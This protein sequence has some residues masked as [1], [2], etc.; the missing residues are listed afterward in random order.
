MTAANASLGVP[1][2]PQEMLDFLAGFDFLLDD[3][4]GFRQ[5]QTGT[6]Q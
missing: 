2:E 4:D 3:G 6:V 1:Q 5:R